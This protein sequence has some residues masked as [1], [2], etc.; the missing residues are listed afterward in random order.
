MPGRD[1]ADD[2]KPGDWLSHITIEVTALADQLYNSG[3]MGNVESEAS[4]G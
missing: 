1:Q 3:L 2:Q 4:F